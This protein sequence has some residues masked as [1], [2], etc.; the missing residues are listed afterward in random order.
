[1]LRA[2]APDMPRAHAISDLERQQIALAQT[3]GT[4]FRAD[5]LGHLVAARIQEGTVLDIGCGA[6]DLVAW[7]GERGYDV[8]GIDVSEPVVRAARDHLRARNLN[9]D[10]IEHCS[11]ESF[12]ERGELADNVVSMECLEHIEDDASAFDSLVVVARPG[13][14]LIVSVPAM[15]SLFG[16]KDVAVGHYR[17]YTADQ[18]KALANRPDLRIDELRYWNLLGVAPT[19]F[20]V[21]LLKRAV[22]DSFRFGAPGLGNRILRRALSPW[23]RYVENRIAP[24]FGLTLIM[25]ATV[26]PRD[27]RA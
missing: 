25:V 2:S 8:R 20:A 4:D 13:G 3:R 18:L 16:P 19:F 24:P 9:P 15:P 12:I 17:R 7:L 23:F 6:G 14:R 21:R 26:L 10:W 11:I 22:D 1:L 5:A 27:G